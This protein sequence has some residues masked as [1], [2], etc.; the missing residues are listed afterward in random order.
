MVLG[1]HLISSA[2][3][4]LL[5]Q[6]KD[7]FDFT[8]G[9]FG[10]VVAVTGDAHQAQ[11]AQDIFRQEVRI[12]RSLRIREDIRDAHQLMIDNVQ[13]QLL[14][15]NIVLGV[16]FAVLI[17]GKPSD[18]LK[19]PIWIQEL[20][21]VFGVWSIAFSFL[22]VWLALRFQKLVSV[23]A[24]RRLLEKHRV[25]V[26]NDEVVGRMGGLSLA[27]KVAQLHES[28]LRSAVHVLGSNR[29]MGNFKEALVQYAEVLAEKLPQLVSPCCQNGRR[30]PQQPICRAAPS[31]C[32]SSICRAAPS[33]CQSSSNDSGP[34]IPRRPTSSRPQSETSGERGTGA[35]QPSSEEDGAPE[36]PVNGPSL[37]SRQVLSESWRNSLGMEKEEDP[38]D[39]DVIEF[40]PGAPLPAPTAL[41]DEDRPRTRSNDLLAIR[42]R[43]GVHAWVSSKGEL[44]KHYIIDLPDFLMEQ[45]LVR[46]PWTVP[47]S[48]DFKTK[49]FL[50]RGAV[51]LYV[52]A[53]WPVIGGAEA[54]RANGPPRD[55]RR[56]ELPRLRRGAYKLDD[57]RELAFCRVEGFSILVSKD[58]LDLPLYRAVIEAPQQD[59]GWV[60]VDLEFRFET[61]FEAPVVIFRGGQVLTSEE[62]WPAVEF[63][64]ETSKVQPLREQSM[65]FMHI[66]ILNLFLSAYFAH[67][68]RVLTDRPWPACRLEVVVISCA[69][70]P[71][72][73]LSIVPESV[74]QRL[75]AQKKVQEA[76]R[77]MAA[78]RR[79]EELN[80]H[81]TAVPAGAGVDLEDESSFMSRP[82]QGQGE[83]T[84][85]TAIP[86][87]PWCCGIQDSTTGQGEQ[88]DPHE[89]NIPSPST[90]CDLEADN[91]ACPALGNGARLHV[92]RQRQ[93]SSLESELS[94]TSLRRIKVKISYLNLLWK[95]ITRDPA[96]V[97]FLGIKVI[98]LAS[99]VVLCMVAALRLVPSTKTPRYDCELHTQWARHEVYGIS[100]LFIP[101]AA[102]STSN[103]LLWVASDWSLLS[104]P[105]AGFQASGGHAARLPAPAKGLVH[106]SRRKTLVVADHISLHALDLNNVNVSHRLTSKPSTAGGNQGGIL[107]MYPR[108]PVE[109]LAVRLPGDDIGHAGAVAAARLPASQAMNGTDVLVVASTDGGLY[110]LSAINLVDAATVQANTTMLVAAR[111]PKAHGNEQ[112]VIRSMYLCFSGACSTTGSVLWTISAHGWL[113]AVELES[114]SQMGSW[115]WASILPNTQAVVITGNATHLTAVAKRSQDAALV[116]LAASFQDLLR[117]QRSSSCAQ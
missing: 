14:M 18:P 8:N 45:T 38:P 106:S 24:R 5:S 43:R 110:L 4:A 52:A 116:V 82:A 64:R 103:G 51:T 111:L 32:Q 37:P 59:D 7:G 112:E 53:Q 56:E 62:D 81:T 12:E 76:N 101:T 113:R 115:P 117:P 28:G 102:T 66:S 9:L 39:L 19:A 42:A 85:I 2:A 73:V 92:S 69:L 26:P 77:F 108:V 44:L 63:L 65:D 84:L 68:G 67:L 55:W 21:A 49:H 97:L 36:E 31:C 80:G 71:A 89:I 35:G 46:C 70:L 109:L 87:S 23:S 16:C 30:C 105:D 22:S 79:T 10:S 50:V 86:S 29:T 95:R 72:M 107:G 96:R 33:C 3:D 27:T 93:L 91:Q 13:T 78:H 98:W 83:T 94:D 74:K 104:L 17:E 99:L 15:G 100:P 11:V 75:V 90:S 25:C 40:E 6:F 58:G 1:L 48:S 60:K 34:T 114:G 20:W 57:G 47:P 88:F 61:E 54:F 41:R